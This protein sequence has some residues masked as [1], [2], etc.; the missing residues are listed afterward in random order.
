[1]K[2]EVWD[3]WNLLNDSVSEFLSLIGRLSD[4]PVDIAELF[5]ALEEE[6]ANQEYFVE[7]FKTIEHYEAVKQ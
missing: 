5:Q 4:G 6:L 2:M 7:K 1:M 3:R